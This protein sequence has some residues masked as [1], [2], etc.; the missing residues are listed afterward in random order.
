MH[1]AGRGG[2]CSIT[3]AR[4]CFGCE[5]RLKCS[6][7]FGTGPTGTRPVDSLPSRVEHLAEFDEAGET[8]H[9]GSRVEHDFVPPARP[10]RVRGCAAPGCMSNASLR[11]G[12]RPRSARAPTSPPQRPARRPFAEV[13]QSGFPAAA[14]IR[15]RP[16]GDSRTT[17]A[18]GFRPSGGVA[19]SQKLQLVIGERRHH[20]RP[21]CR[22]SRG[23][24]PP[25]T[26]ALPCAPGWE[27]PPRPCG[28]FRPG[29]RRRSPESV[30]LQPSSHVW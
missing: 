2:T 30:A 27:H 24:T 1:T 12:V 5:K 29:S 3:E 23:G 6:P 7:V 21:K 10:T 14:A 19:S 9:Q 18:V 20:L 17:V 11:Q 25:L 4:P 22:P 13:V 26:S 28:R 15:R 16:I 8:L